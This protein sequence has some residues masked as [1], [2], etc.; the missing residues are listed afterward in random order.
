MTSIAAVFP[1]GVVLEMHCTNS[2]PIDGVKC[3]RVGPTLAAGYI[4]MECRPR[5]SPKQDRVLANGER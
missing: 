1:P 2:C 4:L 3:T 5:T